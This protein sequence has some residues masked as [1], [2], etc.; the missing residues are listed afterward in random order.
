[1]EMINVP[2][3]AFPSLVE[4]LLSEGHRLYLI[5]RHMTVKKEFGCD[6]CG[7]GIVVSSPDDQHTILSLEKGTD[8]IERKIVCGNP[9]CKKENVRHWHVEAGPIFRST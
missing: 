6:H 8:S 3:Q 7:K 1:M 4:A 9:D 5:V 2:K